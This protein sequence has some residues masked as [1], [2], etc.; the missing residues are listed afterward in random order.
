[1]AEQAPV[2]RY[3]VGATCETCGKELLQVSTTDETEARE[4]VVRAISAGEL[5]DCKKSGK[6][7]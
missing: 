5:H 7:P 1:M 3:D 6:G 4:G 2:V